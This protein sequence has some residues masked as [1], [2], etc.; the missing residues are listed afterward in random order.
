MAINCLLLNGLPYLLC[1][2]PTADEVASVPHLIPLMLTG[3]QH[4]IISDIHT[5]Y[6]VAA[7]MV[8]HCTFVECG[9]YCL[10]TDAIYN[11]SPDYSDVI[12]DLL[13]AHHTAVF[14]NIYHV[15]AVESSPI[16]HNVLSSIG[17]VKQLL[18]RFF[19]CCL[20]QWGKHPGR[21]S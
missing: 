15:H 2:S 20:F 3:I 4:H 19:L 5:F 16:T 9:K 14:Q 21:H 6:D 1:P 7:D 12:D 13:D 8:H 11:T 10:H 18:Q 17:Y